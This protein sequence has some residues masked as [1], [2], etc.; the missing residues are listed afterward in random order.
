MLVFLLPSIFNQ[1]KMKK[2]S[3]IFSKIVFWIENICFYIPKEF[4]QEL[5]L[6]PYIYGRTLFYTI[7]FADRFFCIYQILG[8]AF[9]G[10]FFLLYGICFD[11]CNFIKVLMIVKKNEDE[12]N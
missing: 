8:W 4:M 7:K 6:M 11:M 9:L 3:I 1:D 12:D 2:N 5:I 10:P